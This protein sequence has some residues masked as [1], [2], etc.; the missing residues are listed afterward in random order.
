M[1]LTTIQVDGNDYTAYASLD[2]ANIYLRVEPT[3]WAEWAQQPDATK[4]QL[5]IAA[6]RRVDALLFIG[7]KA[8][9][10][11]PT[12]WPR[13]GIPG[14][15]A[16]AIPPRVEQAAILLASTFIAT[17]EGSETG[18][19]GSIVKSIKAGSVEIT[20]FTTTER[21]LQ[22]ASGNSHL[23]SLVDQRAALLLQPYVLH[24]AAAATV[25]PATG[26]PVAA[27]PVG[28]R[29]YTDGRRIGPLDPDNVFDRAEGVS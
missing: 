13:T 27:P 16:D 22:G 17:P 21:S 5:L 6:T 3:R 18:Q 2:E 14:V 9:G 24:P 8:A 25:D 7:A 23:D 19:S 4:Q 15:D 12:E 11:Q 10:G 26:R 28:Q 29:Y 20:N 1:S